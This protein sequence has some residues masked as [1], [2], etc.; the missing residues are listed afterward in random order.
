[1]RFSQKRMVLNVNRRC[2]NSQLLWDSY[3]VATCESSPYAE[4]LG[5]TEQN[6]KLPEIPFIGFSLDPE[7]P[8]SYEL[9]QAFLYCPRKKE[10]SRRR[11]YAYRPRL[12]QF[13]RGTKIMAD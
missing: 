7:N 4:F 2:N 1:M 6:A 3:L 10:G 13:G 8:K 5:L 12:C 9:M 11:P